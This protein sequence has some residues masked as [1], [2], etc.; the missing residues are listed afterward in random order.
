MF[1]KFCYKPV[2]DIF[3][4]FFFFLKLIDS[5]IHLE[6]WSEEDLLRV[7]K[8]IENDS[9]TKENSNTLRLPK[10]MQPKN[11]EKD[12]APFHTTNMEERDWKL[13]LS[14]ANEVSYKQGDVIIE[15]GT[16]NK[17]LYRIKSGQC[18]V[19]KVEVTRK[20][21]FYFWIS[22]FWKQEKGTQRTLKVLK[23]NEIFGEMSLF[24]FAGVTSASI[25]AATPSVQVYAIDRQFLENLFSNYSRLEKRFYYQV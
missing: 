12:P 8:L 16:F 20:G 4:F 2:L 5:L 9:I 21:K 6:I 1:D 10:S 3:L 18:R 13:L 15:Q 23:E 14:C 22:F 24:D 19:L 17:F 7:S 25:V 11:I